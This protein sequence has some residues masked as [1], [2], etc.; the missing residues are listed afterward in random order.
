MLTIKNQARNKKLQAPSSKLQRTSKLQ[1]PLAECA[2]ETVWNLV[3]G[4][5]LE[6]GA[7]SLE[8]RR[9]AWSFGP[10]HKVLLLSLVLASGCTPPGPSALLEGKRLIERRKY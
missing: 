2:V 4:A 1:A 6:L 10:V 5:S 8:L 3:S 9:P 7:W